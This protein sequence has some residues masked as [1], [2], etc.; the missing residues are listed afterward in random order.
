MAI[1]K[2]L[3]SP[4][5]EVVV[6]TRTHVKA[7]LLPALVLI[8]TM[9]LAGY[10]SAKVSGDLRRPLLWVI[11]LVALAVIVYWPVTA[12]VKWMTTT[13]TVTNRRLIT[14][15]GVI[16]RKGHDIPIPRISDVASERGLLDRMLGCGTLVLADASNQ[17]VR[18]HDIPHLEQVQLQISDL[19]HHGAAGERTDEKLNRLDDGT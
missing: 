13:Y 1:S 8:V 4:G 18:L 5:E 7:M 16:T 11:W 10:L 12:F 6:E 14:R 19:L 15:T 2:K 17:R 3:L 9:G